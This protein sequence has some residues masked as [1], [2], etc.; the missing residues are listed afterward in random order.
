[1]FFGDM[2]ASKSFIWLKM[3]LINYNAKLKS[4]YEKLK[5]KTINFIMH[6]FVNTYKRILFLSNN[7]IG[8]LFQ[9]ICACLKKAILMYLH[10][11][12]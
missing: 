4:M 3:Y 2:Q 9:C 12:G 1:M 7:V 8:C 11:Q 6:F 5:R 10:N